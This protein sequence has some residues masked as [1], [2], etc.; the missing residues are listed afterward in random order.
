M[1]VVSMGE[2]PAVPRPCSDMAPAQALYACQWRRA[3][4]GICQLFAGRLAH[5]LFRVINVCGVQGTTTNGRYLL[6]FRTGAFLAGVP[7]Q[8]VIIKYGQVGDVCQTSDGGC[9]PYSRQPTLVTAQTL[10]LEAAYQCP[11]VYLRV[12]QLTHAF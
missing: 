12:S 10:V 9:V 3:L 5:W 1:I 6:P 4:L 2:T 8:P 11:H 7:V